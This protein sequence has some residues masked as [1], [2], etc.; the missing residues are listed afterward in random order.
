MS[1][2]KNIKDFLETS[3]SIITL[4]KEFNDTK[5][6]EF[7]CN[8]CN[9]VNSLTS[10]SYTNKKSKVTL[11]D[12]CVNCK[13][14]REVKLQTIDFIQKIKEQTGHIVKNVDFSTR[15][16][17]YI[18]HTCEK[19]NQTFVCNIQKQNYPGVCISCQNDCNRLDF[20]VIEKIVKEHQ[21]TLV[22]KSEEYKNNKQKLK[23]IC[24][25]GEP[26]EAVLSDVKRDKHCK[27]CK[28][29]KIKKTRT[30]SV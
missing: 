29:E 28:I 3:F 11:E 7:K 4:E 22:T 6:I 19:E 20:S 16:V 21:M 15:K 26:Y 17:I 8:E 10:S 2:Y 27:V 5:K 23:L 13:K 30:S 14:Q 12:F 25:C 1:K 18:C 24:K 9:H